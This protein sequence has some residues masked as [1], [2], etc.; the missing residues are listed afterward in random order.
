MYL[1]LLL[2]ADVWLKEHPEKAATLRGEKASVDR[3]FQVIAEAGN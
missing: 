3:I 1:L 2:A